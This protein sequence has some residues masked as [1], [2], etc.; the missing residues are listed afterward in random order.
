VKRDPRAS[1]P[2]NSLPIIADGP[3]R[4]IER[5]RFGALLAAALVVGTAAAAWYW[6]QNLTLSHYDARAHL[7]V[8]RRIID[9][10]TPGWQQIGAVWLPLPHLVNA[11]P[12]QLDWAYRTG[13]VATAVSIG[14]LAWGLAALGAR[15]AR[16]TGSST[17]GAT[18]LIVVLLN[19]NLLYLQSTPM[20]EPMLVGFSMLAL[21]A[22]DDWLAHPGG[23]T[24]RRAG[25]MLVALML[26]RYEGWFIAG[27][28]VGLAAASRRRAGARE[29]LG[30]L[31]YAAAAVLGFM[32]L[33]RATIGRWFV[34]GG[35]YEATNPA[36]GDPVAT[37]LQILGS[38]RNLAGWPVL[39]MAAAG[40]VTC[41]VV[42]RRR[43]AA[44]LPLSLFAAGAL[45]FIAFHA[46]HP[47]RVRYMVPLAVA[48]GV[49]AAIGCAGLP[50]RA[51]RV[52]AVGLVLLTL[53]TRP[54]LDPEAPMVREAQWDTDGQRERGRVTR[55]LEREWDGSPILASMGSLAHYMQQ[56]SRIGLRIRDYVHEGN[57]VLW[58]AAVEAPRHHVRWVLIEERSEGGDQLARRAR[59]DATFL[60]G[61]ER[62]A[63][64]AGVAL[65]RRTIK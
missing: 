32:A 44:L 26:T 42:S 20:T 5:R 65:Y 24:R 61:F 19:P 40:M 34:T 30:L 13:L 57:G 38:T 3:A 15:L 31:P 45:P 1:F 50:S 60:G 9:S 25:W 51:R 58:V 62:V 43:P 55:Y 22:V 59:T 7:V 29:A 52:A 16:H 18:A 35:F 41:L 4:Q 12:V 28:L 33:S 17:I 56:T 37:V 6:R 14:V 49:L 46:G 63:E 47:H 23:R 21:V 36:G 39:V 11:L 54:P 64:G 48:S 53:V 8:A 27:G 2:E 10:L